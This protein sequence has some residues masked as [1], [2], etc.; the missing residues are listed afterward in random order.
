MMTIFLG[1]KPIKGWVNTGVNAT[2]VLLNDA[3]AFPHWKFKDGPTITGMGGDTTS[4]NTV[5]PVHWKD[6]DGNQGRLNLLCQMSPLPYPLGIGP[7]GKNGF[8]P[9]Y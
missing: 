3:K 5:H 7:F 9:Y 4:K 1:G 8:C 2:I 6:L